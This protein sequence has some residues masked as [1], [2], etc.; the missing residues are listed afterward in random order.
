MGRA[1]A[2]VEQIVAQWKRIVGFRSSDK[3][4]ATLFVENMILERRTDLP[5]PTGHLAVEQVMVSV[6][7]GMKP[8]VI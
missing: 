1:L 7:P 6:K 8:T 4:L 2:P 3:R 5:A